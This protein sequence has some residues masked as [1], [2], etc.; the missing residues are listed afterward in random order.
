MNCELYKYNKDATKAESLKLNKV[1]LPS[2]ARIGAALC[3]P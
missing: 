2:L 3:T 1:T